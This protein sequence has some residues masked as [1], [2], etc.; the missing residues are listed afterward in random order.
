M[1][2]EWMLNALNVHLK[3]KLQLDPRRATEGQRP[4][5]Q[6]MR[7]ESLRSRR[8]LARRSAAAFLESPAWSRA[9]CARAIR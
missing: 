8:L 4:L 9:R 7:T 2:V 5:S 6:T 3:H 1:D